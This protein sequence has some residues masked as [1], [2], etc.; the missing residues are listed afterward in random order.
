MHHCHKSSLLSAQHKV[1]VA[2]PVWL[3]SCDTGSMCEMVFVCV[4]VCV[5]IWLIMIP[6]TSWIEFN[7]SVQVLVAAPPILGN[8]KYTCNIS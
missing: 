2:R 1:K 4:H 3:A 8:L 6:W 5:E 7:L